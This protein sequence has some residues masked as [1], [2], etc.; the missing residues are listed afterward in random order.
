MNK[1]GRQGKPD[2]RIFTL[3]YRKRPNVYLSNMGQS[4]KN[5]TEAKTFNGYIEAKSYRKTLPEPKD[6]LIERIA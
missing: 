1:R 6:W 3:A 5:T 4:T 2:D